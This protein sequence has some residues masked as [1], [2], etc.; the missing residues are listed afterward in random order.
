KEIAAISVQTINKQFVKILPFFMTLIF[1]MLKLPYT[2]RE[3]F[4]PVKTL[5]KTFCLSLTLQNDMI[6]KCIDNKG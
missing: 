4:Y 2:V 6:I 3:I 1:Y 5:I